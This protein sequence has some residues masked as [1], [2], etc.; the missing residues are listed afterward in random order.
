MS[1]GTLCYCNC[2]VTI[3]TRETVISISTSCSYSNWFNKLSD[4]VHSV[5]P[6][7]VQQ[8]DRRIPASSAR[9]RNIMLPRE[10]VL[11][12]FSTEFLPPF[13]VV[14]VMRVLVVTYS[15]SNKAK[16]T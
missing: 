15:S 4:Y 7:S 3:A 14:E 5:C 1:F 11:T 6:F 9:E 16:I 2:E 12:L 13:K 10:V 8:E